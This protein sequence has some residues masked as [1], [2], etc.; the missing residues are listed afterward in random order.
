MK[1]LILV[2]C[3]ILPASVLAFDFKNPVE[4][5][6]LGLKSPYH[7][8]V[9]DIDYDTDLDFV[10]SFYEENTAWFE[11]RLLEAEKD[12]SVARVLRSSE[13]VD[14]SMTALADFDDDGYPDIAF[15]RRLQYA[16]IGSDLEGVGWLRNEIALSQSDDFSTITYLGSS[17]QTGSFIFAGKINSD[18]KPDLLAQTSSGTYLFENQTSMSLGINFNQSS[19]ISSINGTIF[20]LSDLDMD[21]DLDI[22]QDTGNIEW[23][24]NNLNDNSGIWSNA[25]P[26]SAFNPSLFLP[27]LNLTDIDLDLDLDIIVTNVAADPQSPRQTFT[28]TNRLNEPANDFLFPP[29]E[30][31]KINERENEYFPADLDNDGDDDFIVPSGSLSRVYLYENR[32]LEAE[33]DVIEVNSFDLTNLVLDIVSEDFD[34]DGDRDIV[35]SIGNRDGA[36]DQAILYLENNLLSGPSTANSNVWFYK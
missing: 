35:I 2:T 34:Q 15:V 32:L 20:T 26:V 17:S 9:G 18:D 25:Q 29:S 13:A 24:Q 4:L 31:P 8:S 6:D 30:L 16:T 14:S 36:S 21:N 23:I 12:F 27:K 19:S 11:N 22:L 28:I 5:E 1:K 33:N 7:I 10:V 3:A